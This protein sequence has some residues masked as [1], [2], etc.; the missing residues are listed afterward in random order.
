ML[1]SATVFAA[2]AAKA[3]VTVHVQNVP[4]STY[5]GADY[6]KQNFAQSL[7]YAYDSVLSQMARSVAPGAPF[8]ETHW[9]ETKWTKLW[10][11]T[12][13]TVDD[14]K[15]AELSHELQSGLWNDGG[16]IYWGDFPVVDGLAPKLQGV[17]GD[18]GGPLG[19][20]D[21]SP[22]GC[23]PDVPRTGEAR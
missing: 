13:A 6:L 22:G 5:F 15:R 12:L 4:A 1:E 17:V 23:R 9:N 10:Y 19:A 2:E 16:Y 18:C 11:E 20:G 21:S 8:N 7:W 14:A 3:G